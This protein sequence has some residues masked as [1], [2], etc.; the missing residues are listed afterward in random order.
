M[1]NNHKSSSNINNI[2][3]NNYLK[4][5]K[6]NNSLF[7][8]QELKKSKSKQKNKAINLNMNNNSN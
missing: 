3:L 4:D 1:N 8:H 2:R 7:E 5:N 6:N